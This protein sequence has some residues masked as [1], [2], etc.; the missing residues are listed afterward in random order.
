MPAELQLTMVFLTLKNLF[1][2]G[3]FQKKMMVTKILRMSMIGGQTN[4]YKE[5]EL[6]CQ[7]K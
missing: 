2:Q 6:Y 1:I 5:K 7:S 3:S 4:R